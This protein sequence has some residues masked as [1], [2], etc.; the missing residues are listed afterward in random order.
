[1][2]DRP[3]TIEHYG[4]DFKNHKLPQAYDTYGAA[5]QIHSHMKLIPDV[6]DRYGAIVLNKEIK[7][8][9]SFEVDIKGLLTSDIS[10]SHG[11]TA[12]FLADRPQFPAEFNQEFGYRTDYKGLGV[13]VYRSE[14]RGKWY[15]VAI[16]NKGL[17]SI[18]RTRNID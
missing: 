6:K 14:S 1:M 7:D 9:R 17:Q 15:I 18:T 8:A 12:M 2:L 4:F 10:T 16:Q 13:F 5:V 11:F 3:Q